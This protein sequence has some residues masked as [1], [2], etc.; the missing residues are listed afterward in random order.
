MTKET[1]LADRI[2]KAVRPHGELITGVFFDVDDGEDIKHDGPDDTYKLDITILHAADPD[3]LKAGEAAK[4]AA[5]V[6]TKAFKGKLFTPNKA[7]K[8]IEL[9]SCD[10]VSESVLSYQE[11]KQLRKWR[12]EHLSLSADPQQPLLAE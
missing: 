10:P 11:F 4:E 6:I 8:Q 3:F 9:R 2:A 5:D 12:L 1:K 7:W